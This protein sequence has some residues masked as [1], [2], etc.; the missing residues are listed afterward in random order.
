MA[1]PGELAYYQARS[2][3]PANASLRSH[4]LAYFQAQTGLGGAVSFAR[5]ELAFY[6]AQSA[7]P[8]ASLEQARMAYLKA[9]R[10]AILEGSVD[11]YL[12]ALFAA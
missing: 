10:P 7:L 11:R 8:D 1:R 2:G 9:Q 5:A 12:T 4:K 6:R 3:L